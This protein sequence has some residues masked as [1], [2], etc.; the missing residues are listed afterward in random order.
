MHQQSTPL[1]TPDFD[2][3]GEMLIVGPCVRYSFQNMQAAIAGIPAQ[4]ERF[5][6]HIG[7]MAGQVEAAAYGVCL[8]QVP[9]DGFRYLCGV[10]V[11]ELADLPDR[12]EYVH[13]P[14]N[15]YAVF[16]HAGHVSELPRTL[17]AIFG[18][19]LPR[20]GHRLVDGHYH[21]ERYDSEYD[22]ASGEGGV[23]IRVPI[24]P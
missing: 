24:Q 21:L 20:S 16:V 5:A 18:E 1:E 13:L 15:R 8:D 12:F 4:W 17:D 19:W 2:N 9:G 3:D 6:P 10:R 7:K 14:P 22:R 23:E 11:A